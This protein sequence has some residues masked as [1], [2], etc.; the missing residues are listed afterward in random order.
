MALNNATLQA[1]G[2]ELATLA[3]YVSLHSA[4]PGTTGTNETTA[5]R[6]AAGW[7]VD[8]DGDLTASNLAFSGGASGGTVSHVGLWSAS[9]GGT[10]RG[11]VALSGDTAF[12]ASGEYTVTSLAINGTAS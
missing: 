9:T 2:N 8:S 6:V 11:S 5:A 4:D 12:N 1:L 7:T 3:P 10:Y